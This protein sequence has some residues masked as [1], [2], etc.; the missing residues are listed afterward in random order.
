MYLSDTLLANPIALGHITFTQKRY[1]VVTK[2]S[3]RLHSIEA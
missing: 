3:Y 2:I 1:A